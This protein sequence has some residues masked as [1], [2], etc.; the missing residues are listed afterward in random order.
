MPKTCSTPP[1]KGEVEN[2]ALEYIEDIV[3]AGYQKVSYWTRNMMLNREAQAPVPY[4]A[5]IIGFADNLT[6]SIKTKYPEN[7]NAYATETVV[8]AQKCR[9]ESG[10]LEE[11]SNVNNET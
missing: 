10:G 5:T 7:V 4:E 2:Y 3:I 9:F 11:A 8:L 6:V 1:I